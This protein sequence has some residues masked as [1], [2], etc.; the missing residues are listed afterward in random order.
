MLTIYLIL[1]T[2]TFLNIELGKYLLTMVFAYN[3]FLLYKFKRQQTFLI[4]LLF[5]STYW[6]YMF[7]YFYFGIPYSSYLN[8]QTL[9]NTVA[10]L[11]IQS[12]F[13]ILLF[14]LINIHTNVELASTIQRKENPVIFYCCLVIMLVIALFVLGGETIFEMAYGEGTTRTSLLEYYF[15][16]SLLAYVFSVSKNKSKLIFAINMFYALKLILVGLR[17]VAIEVIVLNFLL[18]YEN[19]LKTKWII[20]ISSI[21][22]VLLTALSF[23]RVGYYSSFKEMVGFSDQGVLITNQGDVFLASVVHYGMVANEYFDLSFRLKSFIGFWLNIFLPP[24]YQ[25]QEA[26]LNHNVYPYIVGGGGF[27]GVYA[28]V[29]LNYIGIFLLAL[30]ISYFI[31]RAYNNKKSTIYATFI[32]FTFFRWYPYSLI[33]LF[34]MGLWLWIIYISCLLLH[35]TLKK[36]G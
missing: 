11:R 26:I 31:N 1:F 21:I 20:L 27:S 9:E 17:L 13:F 29:W 7:F 28:Y 2:M 18:F 23:V 22:S 36:T 24:E 10:V 19:Q 15:I 12:L 16:F 33:I 35:Q 6:F 30:Y 5:A 14:N 4:L 8:M 32:I 34:K 3:I 25:I